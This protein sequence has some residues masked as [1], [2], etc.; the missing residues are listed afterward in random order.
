MHLSTL[1]PIGLPKQTPSEVKVHIK[2]MQA[3]TRT[4]SVVSSTVA[5]AT[6]GAALRVAFGNL[7]RSVPFPLAVA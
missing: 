3:T 2:R 5:S 1:R 7:C 4:T 6:P